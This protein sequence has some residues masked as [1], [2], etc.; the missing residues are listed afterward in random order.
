MNTK[1]AQWKRMWPGQKTH[2][3]MPPFDAMRVLS[4]H[5]RVLAIIYG[6]K[7]S[8]GG[9]IWEAYIE[10]SVL[11]EMGYGTY[12]LGRYTSSAS[13]MI[14]VDA[15]LRKLVPVDPPALAP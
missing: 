12:F 5:G 1:D 15:Y 6:I 13:A 14:R 3:S 4:L 8:R 10:H 7:C 9:W 2:T 11:S